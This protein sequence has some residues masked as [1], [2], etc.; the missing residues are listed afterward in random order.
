MQHISIIERITMN[1]RLMLIGL[2]CFTFIAIFVTGS[3]LAQQAAPD[4]IQA[5]LVDLSAQVSGEV[6]L[7]DL[8][9]YTYAEQQFSDASLGCPAP[10][11]TYAQVITPGY[12]FT[13]VYEGISY[14]YRVS[15]DQSSIVLCST[16]PVDGDAQPA[17]RTIE[18]NQPAVAIAP[19]G[20]RRVHRWI[21]S[22]MDSHAALAF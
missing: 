21:S 13:L 5:A 11:Q 6:N 1:N 7:D 22:P 9:S 8:A 20:A 4:Q 17:P 19:L 10:D 18:M 15:E 12:Q 14:D 2:I 16:T 3:V